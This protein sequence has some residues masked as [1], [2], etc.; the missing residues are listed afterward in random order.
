MLRPVIC[1][2]FTE[3]SEMLTASIIRTTMQAASTLEMLMNF[4]QTTGLDIP[5]DSHI[6]C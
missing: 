3:V 5:E 4:H 1:Y 6:N 2:K